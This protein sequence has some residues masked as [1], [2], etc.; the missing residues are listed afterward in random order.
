[1]FTR[2]KGRVQNGRLRVDEPVDLP[3]GSKVELVIVDAEDGL[4]ADDRARLHA[5]L[6]EAHEEFDRGEGIPVGDVISKARAAL[7][8]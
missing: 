7:S 1:M 2:V 8:K 3:E 5:A 6:D 4:E